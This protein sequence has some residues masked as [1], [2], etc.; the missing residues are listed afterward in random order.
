MQNT[1]CQNITYFEKCISCGIYNF[2]RVQILF[3]NAPVSLMNKNSSP[4]A[5][6]TGCK[7]KAICVQERAPGTHYFLHEELNSTLKAFLILPYQDSLFWQKGLPFHVG[8]IL[9]YWFSVQQCFPFP[10]HLHI[11]Q[12]EMMCICH[13]QTLITTV[14]PSKTPCTE[15]RAV[16][17]NINNHT[18]GSGT[19]E[20]TKETSI[21]ACQS[22]LAWRGTRCGTVE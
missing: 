22:V 3:T 19:N 15:G 10:Q 1:L 13:L 11:E 2:S 5:F 20:W 21:L 17:F 7:C 6:H 16:S 18:V 12:L 9:E 8:K 14:K 4:W